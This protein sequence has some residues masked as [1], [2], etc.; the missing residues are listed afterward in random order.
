MI[1]KM[2]K[3]TSNTKAIFWDLQGTL[4]GEATEDGLI[5]CYEECKNKRILFNL[6]SGQVGV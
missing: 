2:D 4:G 5:S 6:Q 3:K 1:E